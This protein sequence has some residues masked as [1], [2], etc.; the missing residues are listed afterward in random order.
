MK[1]GSG[2][3]R[4]RDVIYPAWHRLFC[5]TCSEIL[6]L[7]VLTLPYQAESVRKT[8]EHS[9]SATQA[10]P[11]YQIIRSA[12]PQEIEPRATRPRRTLHDY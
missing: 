11:A 4:R 7:E 3:S 1:C 5:A 2:I 9:I 6:T 10:R 12:S 8:Y